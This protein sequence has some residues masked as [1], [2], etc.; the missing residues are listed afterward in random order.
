[1]I[2][3]IS[4]LI[5]GGICVAVIVCAVISWV[6]RK[7]SSRGRLYLL[8]VGAFAAMFV[9]LLPYYL[10]SNLPALSK[11]MLTLH[12][13]AQ[14][15]TFDISVGEIVD[16]ISSLHDGQLF[17]WYSRVIS[18][19]AMICPL[20]TIGFILSL[21]KNFWPRVR[22]ALH[23]RKCAYIFPELNEMSLAF[24]KSAAEAKKG[25]VVFANAYEK[26]E[27]DPE[28]LEKAKKIH[29]ICF[30]KSVENLPIHKTKRKWT[31]GIRFIMLKEDESAA[32]AESLEIAKKYQDRP[33]TR[34]YLFSSSAIAGKVID[35]VPSSSPTLSQALEEKISSDVDAIWDI[36]TW[37]NTILRPGRGFYMQ[38]VDPIKTL[39]IQTLSDPAL[40]GYLKEE[41]FSSKK[42]SL[43]IVGLG[44]IGKQLLKTAVWL[45]QVA[46]YTVEINLF[47]N[48]S[49]AEVRELLKQECPELL[50]KELGSRHGDASYD[51]T[52]FSNTDCFSSSFDEL[53]KE[54]QF[55]EH[56]Q[57]TQV[58]FV[59]LGDDDQNINAAVRIRVLFDQIKNSANGNGETD[60]PKIYSV[61]FNDEKHAY[62]NLKHEESRQ[63]LRGVS[64]R[65]RQKDC[66]EGKP[67]TT[68]SSG[69]HNYKKQYYNIRF[70]GNLSSQYCLQTLEGIELLEREAIARHL[71]W[72][73]TNHYVKKAYT[74]NAEFRDTINQ[75]YLARGISDHQ[76]SIYDPL[77][78]SN[79]AEIASSVASNVQDYYAYEYYRDS[80]IATHLHKE[81]ILPVFLGIDSETIIMRKT[82][83]TAMDE[84]S[85]MRRLTEH[86]RWN[87]YMRSMGYRYGA[88]RFDRG[89][90]H[91][92]LIPFE[93]LDPI[94][95]FKD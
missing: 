50:D 88:K 95:F 16:S 58:V 91:H 5:A 26:E 15:F 13:T 86:M 57:R 63:V 42:I 56:L 27:S 53:V 10:E 82:L 92:D 75:M 52:V 76:I 74:E 60:C 41:S 1:M 31:R 37:R 29:A 17:A 30:A 68:I 6:C 24:A 35:S 3:N 62:V 70:V 21:V 28:L 87:A 61:V 73:V 7:W 48:R 90:L 4:L 2:W 71:S 66:S 22:F 78:S 51:I 64:R 8:M 49:D 47:D 80:S 25:L 38:R 67:V 93:E 32:L 72:M 11:I 14:A 55:A 69:I 89:L 20:F 33:N 81:R 19:M 23:F 85:W 9:L 54:G 45:Y 77:A 39:A 79:K 59:T 40:I 34:V 83:L 44:G 65:K 43:M 84:N 94:E 12:S 18:V 36:N 46:G